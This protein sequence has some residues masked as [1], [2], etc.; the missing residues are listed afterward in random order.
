MTEPLTTLLR[1]KLDDRN[2]RNL[3]ALDNP[4]V[5][6]FL[7]EAVKLCQPDSVFI[8]T[9]SQEDVQ[10]VRNQAIALGEEKPLLVPGHT[11][12]FDGINDQGRDR[13][14][15]KYLVPKNDSLSKAINQIEREQ[16]LAEIRGLLKN[17]MK[18]R[19]MIVRFLSLGPTRSIFSI[20]CVQCTDSF[21]VAHSEDLLYR[22]AYEQFR[23]LKAGGDLFFMLHSSGKMTEDMVSVESDKKRIYIDYTRG[24]IY[25]VNTQYAGN[26]MGLK[27]LALRLT[28][29]EASRQGWLAEHM[30]LI[31]VL[32]PKGRKTYFGGAFPSACGK[33]S[34]AMLPDGTIL[35]DDIAYFRNIGG[36]T[37]AVNAERGIFGIIQDIKPS[38][39]P[40]LYKVLTSPGE[41]IF[42]NVLVK[43]GRPYWLGMDCELPKDG[44]NFS[45]PWRLGKTDPQGNPIPPAHK[46]AR[47][48]VSLPAL[49][50]V[51]SE[52]GN[53][54]G[55]VVHG[56]MYGGRDACTYVPVQQSFSWD[57]G[58]IAYGASLETETTFAILGQEGVPELNVMSIQDFL[59]IPIGRYIQNNLN[60]AKGLKDPPLIFG[61]NYFLRGKDGKFLNEVRDKAVWVR[62]MELR[63]HGD[64]G[65]LKGPTGWIPKYEDLQRL[66]QQ[67]FGKDYARKD[68]VQQFQ[69]RIPENLAK[70]E[71]VEAFYR[72]EAP[73]APEALY[74]V[75]A[76]Q[77]QRLLD[78]QKQF[79]DYVSPE[80]L[81][82]E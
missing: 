31:G 48:T 2:Y 27:K 42:S 45:G 63:V 67:A 58:I 62:W 59:A 77:R 1:S 39:E 44:V 10:Y 70:I 79:G 38:T 18:G 65:A 32:G 4:R 51:D 56:L 81:P 16:G 6:R 8:C 53:P 57:H 75:L 73:D 14:V 25:S 30:F 78:A 76:D 52:L 74:K 9:D 68:Y 7:A 60:F 80:R 21:Y 34:T 19:V 47:Y 3:L 82:T 40:A 37:H 5:S 72:A 50:N 36:E 35:G 28:I 54:L 29:R 46:N 49:E 61:V 43:D 23:S 11:V 20:P 24:T 26:T 55:V 15:T 64:V 71:R 66:F 22:P 13:E 69:I 17:S 33:T 41:I 12:H